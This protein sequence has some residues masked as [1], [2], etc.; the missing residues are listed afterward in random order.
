MMK[1]ADLIASLKTVT[2]TFP[3]AECEL[4]FCSCCIYIEVDGK[5]I[6]KLNVEEDRFEY[7]MP[8]PD[9]PKW[10]AEAV[11]KSFKK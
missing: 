6:A 11:M 3:E 9:P 8:L 2:D 4:G 7:L 1:I 5:R 10:L